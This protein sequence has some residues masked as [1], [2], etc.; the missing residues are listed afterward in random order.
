[1]AGFPASESPLPGGCSNHDPQAKSRKSQAI[2]A[3][4]PFVM[5]LQGALSPLGHTQPA[6]NDS[7]RSLASHR[8]LQADCI[9]PLL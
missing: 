1:M 2:F 9:E 7:P 4:K 5:Q 8:H 6:F 3:N